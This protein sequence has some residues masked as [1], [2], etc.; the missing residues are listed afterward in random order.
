MELQLLQ[1]KLALANEM[2]I[3][4]SSVKISD[5][6]RA[7][8]TNN[9]NNLHYLDGS[10]VISKKIEIIL[11]R[12]QDQKKMIRNNDKVY[13]RIY[14]RYLKLTAYK[15]KEYK[16][17][18]NTIKTDEYKDWIQYNLLLG[19]IKKENKSILIIFISLLIG[20]LLGVIMIF[21]TNTLKKR[22]Q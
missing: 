14:D 2:N 16:N 17:H 10:K 1:E 6:N 20:T 22:S 11:N 13:E 3:V 21:I 19:D 7:L 9:N 15:L 8:S 18:I 4:N 5:T 12:S